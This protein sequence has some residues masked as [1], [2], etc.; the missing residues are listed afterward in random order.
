M[1]AVISKSQ[2]NLFVHL[3][4]TG[5]HVWSDHYLH[6]AVNVDHIQFTSYGTYVAND[7]LEIFQFKLLSTA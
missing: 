7:T 4:Q 2:N 6:L 5:I 1:G 3:D